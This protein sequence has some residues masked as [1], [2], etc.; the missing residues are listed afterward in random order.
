M[1]KIPVNII[2]GF[3]GA[4]KTTAILKLFEQKPEGEAWAIVVNE[5]GKIPIDGQIIHSKSKNAAVYEVSG[6]CFC[7]TAKYYLAE[8][9][10]IISSTGKYDRVIIEPSGLGGV[11]MISG[12]VG[13]FQ[14]LEL[15]PVLCIVDITGVNNPKIQ[16]IPLYISQITQSDMI[17]LS[18]W[19][20]LE[21]QELQRELIDKF[22]RAFPDKQVYLGNSL[23]Q[24]YLNKNSI[25]KDCAKGEKTMYHS[26]KSDQGYSTY[27][28]TFDK[29][30]LCDIELLTYLCKQNSKILR[31]KGFLLSDQGWIN[32]NYSMND[33][34]CTPCPQKEKNELVL[35]I[36]N[37]LT[38]S[39]E[40]TNLKHCFNVK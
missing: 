39:V 23:E 35:I 40:L 22:R 18:K 31:G 12:I 38:D 2:S 19:D 36:E 9:L 20:L 28:M 25:N 29:F 26:T 4:G 10:E 30:H 37:E 33:I 3:L 11:D 15:M 13:S 6:G 7:C 32:F 27:E 5:F 24:K 14:F 16:R 8:S 1:K 17:F 34:I 21:S